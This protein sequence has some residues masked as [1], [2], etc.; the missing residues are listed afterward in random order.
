VQVQELVDEEI[1]QILAEEPELFSKSRSQVRAV[2]AWHQGRVKLRE[3]ETFRPMD[4]PSLK[5]RQLFKEIEAA[6]TPANRAETRRSLI[7]L[8]GL[9]QLN[10]GAAEVFVDKILAHFDAK[11]ANDGEG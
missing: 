10:T 5:L 1:R 3:K 4:Q 2:P 9:L 11:H 6:Y 8:G 7:R